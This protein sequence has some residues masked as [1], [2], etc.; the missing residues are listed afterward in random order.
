MINPNDQPWGEPIY[1]YTRAQAIEDGEQVEVS[2]L[3]QEAG[4]KY[5]TFLTRDDDEKPAVD[6]I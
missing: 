2:Q 1:T 5:R 3:A 6:D 4:I